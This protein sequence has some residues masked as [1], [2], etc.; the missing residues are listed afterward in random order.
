MGALRLAGAIKAIKN[1]PHEISQ[2]TSYFTEYFI[3]AR[4]ACGSCDRMSDADTQLLDAIAKT[5]RQRRQALGLSQEELAARAGMS[6]RYVSLLE[7]R[8]HQPSLRT[9][10]GLCAGLGVTMTEFVR[11]VE[12]SLPTSAPH[13][14]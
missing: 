12:A 7:S 6:M 10:R 3:D 14:D 5:L 13:A 9:I 4:G 1:F 11:E 2:H 8:R